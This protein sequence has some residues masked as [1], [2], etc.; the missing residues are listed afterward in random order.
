MEFYN[1]LSKRKET[2]Q[3]GEPGR[4]KMYVCGPTTYNYIHLGN[5]RALVVFDTIRRYFLYK[6]YDVT[7]VQNF[8]DIDDKIIKRAQELNEDPVALAR[9]YIEEYYTDADALNVRR[10]DV[11]PKVSEHIPDIIDMIE[12]LIARGYAYVTGDGNVYFAVR[13]F[14]EYGKLSGRSLDEMRSGAR[15]DVDPNKRDPLDF[16]LWK[17]AKPGE[18]FWD[19]PWGRGRPGWHIECSAMSLKYLGTAFDIHGGGADLIFPH[20]ENEIAQSE[21]ATGET[22]ARYWIHN[23]FITINKEKMSKSLGNIFLVR[24]LLDHYSPAALRLF[25]LGTHYRSP[26]DFDL[27]AMQAAEKAVIRLKNSLML[28]REA[29]EGRAVEEAD[30]EGEDF[31]GKLEEISSRFEKGM[32]DDFNTALGLACWFDLAHETNSYLHRSAQPN[33]SLLE[34]A[35]QLFTDFN[36][37]LG[38]FPEEG[39]EIVLE[40]RKVGDDLSE[41][42]LELLIEVRQDA[43]KQ[44][45]FALADHIRDRLKELGIIL[46]DTPQGVRWRKA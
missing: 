45:N 20:H 28:L 12:R 30:L 32:D 43:R 7:Y 41:K 14:P 23:G 37:I 9:R 40:E 3:P 1:T 35:L 33:R 26:L 6:G 36:G 16:A 19:S 22:F 5:A 21:G 2:F 18:P 39:G 42:L 24:D 34:R 46:E 4:V 25:L 15:V 29:L 11:H 10:A 13:K 31:A 27:D 38:V 8:T 17:A 44:K